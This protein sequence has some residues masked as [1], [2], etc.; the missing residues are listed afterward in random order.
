[1]KLIKTLF[2]SLII[3]YVVPFQAMS[4]QTS[5]SPKKEAG[6]K[7]AILKEVNQYRKSRGLRPLKLNR[8]IT[9]EARRHS[10]DMAGRKIQFSHKGFN[11]RINHIK[12]HI[13]SFRS[14]AENIA[15]FKN[16]PAKMVVKKWL[17]SPGHRRNILG[18]Y[19]LTGI[20]VARS[21]SGWVYYTQIF[22]KTH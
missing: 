15:C 9:V 14:G 10:I 19:H 2:L 8:S 6:Y 11:R 3:C 7:L 18:N 20:G 16:T 21:K 12:N 4:A 1:M 17:T 5:L 22:A 13:S